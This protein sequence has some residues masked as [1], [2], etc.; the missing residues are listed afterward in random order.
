MSNGC[1]GSDCQVQGVRSKASNVVRSHVC[2]HKMANL[3]VFWM[4]FLCTGDALSHCTI[5]HGLANTLQIHILCMQV[6]RLYM[7]NWQQL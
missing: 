2:T 3:S 4:L 5:D 6:G 7:L 1:S